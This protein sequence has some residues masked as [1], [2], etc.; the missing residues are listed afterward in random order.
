MSALLHAPDRT[1]D[2]GYVR[3]RALPKE[4]AL[5]VGSKE[6]AGSSA[7]GDHLA[8]DVVGD[9]RLLCE[10]PNGTFHPR[11]RSQTMHAN[12]DDRMSGEVDQEAFEKVIRDNLSP[13]GVATIIAFLQPAAFYKPANE[14]AIRGLQQA[15]WLADTLTDM[16][17]VDEVNRLFEELGL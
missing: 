4:T 16:L 7:P 15:E 8:L 2:S 13:E 10:C 5:V 9:F 3:I 12:N 6:P 14:D 17:G 1:A 11:T